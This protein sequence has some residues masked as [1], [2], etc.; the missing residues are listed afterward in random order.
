MDT[1]TLNALVSS[2]S[3]PDLDDG[4][5]RLLELTKSGD[6]FT[7]TLDGATVFTYTLTGFPYSEVR[8]ALSASTG[9]LTNN[10]YF[11]DLTVSCP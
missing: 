3:I 2:S 10:H 11:D 6:D 5:E 4:V 8:V 1:T 9:G 7:V